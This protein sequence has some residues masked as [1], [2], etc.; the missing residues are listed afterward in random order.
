MSEA[1]ITAVYD[2]PVDVMHLTVGVGQAYE[3]DGLPDGIEIDYS[4][5]T[6]APCGA[7]IIGFDR[8][9]WDRDVKRLA[10]V[11]A[12]KLEVKRSEILKAI[13]NA[14]PITLGP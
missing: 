9:G 12:A 14:K 4:L 3:G 2:F 7:K 1:R 6:G 11:I 5:E 10:S 13:K 8:Y